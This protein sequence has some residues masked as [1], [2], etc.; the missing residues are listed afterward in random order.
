MSVARLELVVRFLGGVLAGAAAWE[1]GRNQLVASIPALSSW[2]YLTYLVLLLLAVVCFVVAFALTPHL[3]T[4][5]FFW[6]LHKVTH[7]PIVDILVAAGGLFVG[8]LI[9]VPLIWPLSLLP[10][11]GGYL[12]IVVI[13][14][15]GYLGM[16]TVTTHKREI[17]QVLGHTR[18]LG[19]SRSGE[20]GKVLVDTSAIIDGRIAD[21]GQSGFLPGVLVVPRFVLQEL[22]RIADSADALRRNRGRRGMDVLDRLQKQR[23][24]PL[25]V[26]ESELDS[27][28]DVDS[29]LVRLAKSMKCS[30]ITNDYNLNRVA[31]IQ[32][33]KVL[34]INE[35]ANAV[36][37]VVLP[38]EVMAVRVIQEGKELGQGVGYLD[39]GTMVVV[40]N[41][42]SYLNRE[43]EI[44]VLRVLQTAAGRMIFAQPKSAPDSQAAS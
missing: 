7:T 11:L 16:S 35:L 22:Q 33:V 1:V 41:G 20:S 37:A 21:I 5:P 4:R 18:E 3:T 32:G 15:L 14:A 31:A 39:D 6:L 40:E 27:G 30:I 8:L 23:D 38:G 28:Q 43:A 13:L 12:P 19:R 10:F 2:S 34:N 44:V 17:L 26:I 36:K 9:G 24:V 25:E 42:R 29:Q